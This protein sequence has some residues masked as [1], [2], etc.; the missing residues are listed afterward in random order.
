VSII[1][2]LYLPVDLADDFTDFAENPILVP[3]GTQDYDYLPETA[4]K[5]IN[6][7]SFAFTIEKATH[8]IMRY[9]HR[10]A[11]LV[12]FCIPY[13]IYQMGNKD[14]GDLVSDFL[15]KTYV[16]TNESETKSL[17]DLYYPNN[18][19]NKSMA[20]AYR[21]M[22]NIAPCFN[23]KKVLLAPITVASD[24]KTPIHIVDQ[25]LNTK[26][27]AL[28][29]FTYGAFDYIQSFANYHVDFSWLLAAIVS[30]KLF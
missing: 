17:L 12:N 21:D 1:P 16:E 23:R 22:T 11:V 25:Y 6:P 30:T 7:L 15:A 24:I 8:D 4:A 26:G 13:Q 10:A 9:Q 3:T 19:D 14:Y 29:G 27:N 2:K 5:I 18:N 28:S 20:V